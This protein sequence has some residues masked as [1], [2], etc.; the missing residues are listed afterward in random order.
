[1]KKLITLIMLASLAVAAAPAQAGHKHDR[2]WKHDHGYHH[3]WKNK[4]RHG[5]KY[6]HRKH[7]DY[8]YS[9]YRSFWYD[10]DHHDRDGHWGIVFRYFD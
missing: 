5:H 10:R 3:G 4:H 2:H 9:K 7:R 1:M 6:K 8:R